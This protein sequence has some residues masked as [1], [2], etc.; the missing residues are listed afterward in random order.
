MGRK[1]QSAEVVYSFHSSVKEMAVEE[2]LIKVLK[3]LWDNND[4][5]P[6]VASMRCTGLDWFSQGVKDNVV[7]YIA[8]EIF[9]EERA[10]V[11]LES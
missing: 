5:V 4:T 7:K 10:G 8:N 2:K 11:I 9:G 6:G 3:K 1:N